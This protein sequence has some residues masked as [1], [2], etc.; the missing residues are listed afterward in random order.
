MTGVDFSIFCMQEVAI[1]PLVAKIQ[2]TLLKSASVEKL[3]I[4]L[5]FLAY[6]YSPASYYS[7]SP[8]IMIIG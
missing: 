8:K 5:K 4:F 3:C 2:I 6:S 1:P 7:K